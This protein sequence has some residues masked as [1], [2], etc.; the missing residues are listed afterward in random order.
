MKEDTPESAA[1]TISKD[2]VL[3]KEVVAETSKD[4][5]AVVWVFQVYDISFIKLKIFLN[6]KRF[7]LKVKIKNTKKWNNFNLKKKKFFFLGN[8]HIWIFSM[9]KLADLRSNL[10]KEEREEYEKYRQAPDK[11][12]DDDIKVLESSSESTS[13]KGWKKYFEKRK[14][15]L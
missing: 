7:A 8:Y 12:Q 3:N 10:S 1:A 4:D 9:A 13:K 2:A 5:K 11:I 6:F 14:P 15:T